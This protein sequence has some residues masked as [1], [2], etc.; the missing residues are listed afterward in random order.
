L[1]LQIT[2]AGPDGSGATD[3]YIA[4]NAWWA[5]LRF[6]L[7]ELP[8]GRAWYRKIDTL[9]FPPEDIVESGREKRL[10]PQHQ[11]ELAPRSVVVLLGK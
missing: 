9:F 7:P 2:A 5:P 4:A 10:I 6:F 1:S 8:A 11:Y 3:I